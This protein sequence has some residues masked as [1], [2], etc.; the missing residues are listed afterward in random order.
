MLSYRASRAAYW[1]IAL[2]IDAWVI[3]FTTA[4]LALGDKYE[5]D[6]GFAA[7]VAGV[8]MIFAFGLTAVLAYLN[9]MSRIEED[10]RRRADHAAMV[11]TV[12]DSCVA[13]TPKQRVSAVD[14]DTFPEQARL[15]KLQLLY[16]VITAMA[17]VL[18]VRKLLR[19]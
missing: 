14:S 11:I 18:I 13:D 9:G 4:M 19:H 8:F 12:G 15:D 10:A 6:H 17:L 1:T 16:G 2:T 5:V 3:V 7:V